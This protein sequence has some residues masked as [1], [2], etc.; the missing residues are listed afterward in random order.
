MIQAH[1]A[2]DRAVAI[3]LRDARS[4]IGDAEQ[5]TL[6][7]PPYRQHDLGRRHL[8]GGFSVLRGGFTVLRRPRVFDRVVDQIGERLAEQ[9]AI[10]LDRRRF[11]RIDR[12]LR[13]FSSASGS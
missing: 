10:A 3:R 9:F 5:H 13:P 6:A 4:A 2:L 8:R 12:Q 11:R 1:E 7:L